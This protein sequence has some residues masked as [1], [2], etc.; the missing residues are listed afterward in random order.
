MARVLIIF[1]LFGC[2]VTRANIYYVR[3]DGN[4]ANNGAATNTAWRNIWYAAN[5][6]GP[7]DIVSVGAGTFNEYVTNHVS[8]TAG[9]PITFVGMRG[10]AGEWLTIIDPSTELTN[11]IPATEVGAGVY[12]MTNCP[13]FVQEMTVNG[14]RLAWVYTNT[15]LNKTYLGIVYAN[16][17]FTNG[18]QLLTVAAD[19]Q[20]QDAG[21]SQLFPYWDDL[22]AIYC[23]TGSVTYLRFKNGDDPN[24]KN[25]RGAENGNIVGG[26]VLPCVY[27]YGYS[28]VT[29]SNFKF[30]GAYSGLY[31][32]GSGS[33]HNVIQSNYFAGGTQP[34]TIWIGP[35]DNII[36]GNEVFGNYYGWTN[37]GAHKSADTNRLNV[38]RKNVYEIGKYIMGQASSSD[39]GIFL[40][41]PGDNNT[42]C[43]NYCHNGMGEGISIQNTAVK[44]PALNTEIY[45]NTITHHSSCGM[46]LGQGQINTRVHHNVLIDNASNIRIIPMDYVGETNRLVYVYRNLFWLPSTPTRADDQVY[47]YY[48]NQSGPI[49]DNINYWFFYNSFSGGYYGINPSGWAVGRGGCPGIR[50]LNN[51]FCDVTYPFGFHTGVYN[52]WFTTNMIGLCDYNLTPT[53]SPAPDWYGT[54]NIQSATPEWTNVEGMTFA[55][56]SGSKAIDAAIDVTVPFTINGTSYPAL[57]SGPEQKVGPAWDIGAYEFESSTILLPPTGL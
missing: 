4:N 31:M 12:K 21:T 48:S 54:N 28:Y 57:P 49:C 42:V 20:I 51:D 18:L 6:A 56:S 15:T 43:Y 47:I 41:N 26:V 2:F 46:A 8:G 7:G 33:H 35:H 55:S 24:M 36:Q 14:Q 5:V 27:M 30:Q 10:S 34:L 22:G 50:L 11:W 38:I 37:M 13:F 39:Y 17:G 1:V 19:A 16:S 44:T 3:L 40:Y 29:W 25:V 9:N 23:S 53:L 32:K 52:G 45:N